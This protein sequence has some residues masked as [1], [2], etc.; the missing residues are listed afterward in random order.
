MNGQ[1][2]LVVDRRG[3]TLELGSHDTVVLVDADGRR[4]RV[5]MKALGS[6][7]LHGNIALSTG[8]LQALAAHGVALVA[9]PVRGYAPAVGFARMPHGHLTLRHQQHLAYGDATRRLALAR[10]VV[11]AKLEAMTEF[12]RAHGP[13]I[14]PELY[15]AMQSASTAG[16]VA[17][18]MGVEGAATL[19][20]FAVLG[21]LYE[22]G[23]PFRFNGRSRQPPRDEPNALMSLAYTLAQ[24]QATQ[25]ALRSGLDVQLGFLH[26]LHRE[27]ESLALDLLEPARSALDDWGHG[28]LAHQG[29]LATTHFSR[30]EDGGVRLTQEGRALFYPLWFRE[31]FRVALRPMRRLLAGV[32]ETLRRARDAAGP[33]D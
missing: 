17:E 23:S 33:A 21:A 31:G 16:S 22:R 30:L 19:K 32:L 24:G 7:V 14:E 11:L 4:E 13:E 27:R 9:L 25:L 18:L 3:A 2:A 10:R 6:V 28:L 1:L 26:A 8:L 20:H 29:P 5:G 15:A 12:A